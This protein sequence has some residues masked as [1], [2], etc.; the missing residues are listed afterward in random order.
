MSRAAQSSV[1]M[2]L[3]IAVC[4]SVTVPLSAQV[5]IV[6]ENSHQSVSPALSELPVVGVSASFKAPVEAEPVR[7]IPLP[8]GLKPPNE[9][10]LARQANVMKAADQPQPLAPTLLN[11]FEGLGTGIPGFTIAG[12]PPD[13]NGAPGLTQYVQWVNTSLAV[14]N[15]TTGAIIAGPIAGNS[16]F[17]NLGGDCQT[18]NDGDPLVVYDKLANRWVLSQFAVRGTGFH[19]CVAVSTTSDATG[20]YNLYSFDYSAFDDYPKMGTW[21]DAY[22]VTFNMFDPNTSA[23]VGADVC[24][25]QRDAMLNGQPALQ[26]CF[27]QGTSVGSLL[28]SDVDGTAPPPAGSPD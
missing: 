13:T 10:D 7:R 25:Y 5:M 1:W 26:I 16:L 19:Q 27:Q 23:F 14:F 9:P 20:T 22:Y 11:Q 4:L 12:A 21:P 15:K 17:A 28:P 8:A 2:Y 24:A 18:T 3:L 6:R